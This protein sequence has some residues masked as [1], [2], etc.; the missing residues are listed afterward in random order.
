M[1]ENNNS[2]LYSVRLVQ[3]PWQLTSSSHVTPFRP[4]PLNHYPPLIT[5]SLRILITIFITAIPVPATHLTHRFRMLLP[6][7]E[8][9]RER[10]CHRDL[11]L[12]HPPTHPPLSHSLPLQHFPLCL[13]LLLPP[14]YPHPFSLPSAVLFSVCLPQHFPVWR[15][16]PSPA[17]SSP[18][19]L[20]LRVLLLLM[21]LL[22]RVRV[23]PEAAQAEALQLGV[24]LEAAGHVVGVVR[25]VNE[26]LVADL[27]RVRL[28][29][30]VAA[31]VLLGVAPAQEE[32]T[33]ICTRVLALAGVPC[34]H[35]PNQAASP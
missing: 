27:A 7:V 4:P 19:S 29:S 1:D 21:L 16:S 20:S 17:S 13:A 26:F 25:L 15:P 34:R 28:V 30:R 10:G 12:A 5:F 32:L 2:K 3:S 9:P 23:P 24:V 14:S 33:A 11:Y 31:L 8:G 22:L 18:A 35:R 6:V